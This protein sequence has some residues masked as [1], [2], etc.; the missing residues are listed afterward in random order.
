MKL[1]ASNLVRLLEQQPQGLSAKE[2]LKALGL[3]QAK[4]NQLRGVLKGLTGAKTLQR[5]NNRYRLSGKTLPQKRA[6]RK[7]QRQPHYPTGQNR[8]LV[9]WV[10]GEPQFWALG[11]ATPQTLPQV[12]FIDELI[13]GDELTFEVSE[14]GKRFNFKL[15]GRRMNVVK[16]ELTAREG[17]VYADPLPKGM[18]LG[19]Q[20]RNLPYSADLQGREALI[21]CRDLPHET[22]VVGVLPKEVSLTELYR[23]VLAEYEI[24]EPFNPKALAQAEAYGEVEKP[25]DREDLTQIP[26]VTIDGDDA[27]DFDDA[28][29]A[30]TQGEGW[31]VIVAIADVA[32]YVPPGS[33]LDKEASARSTSTYL[34]GYCVPM[35]PEHLSNGL[36]SLQA[37]KPRL[38]LA[39]EMLL[40]A[41]GECLKS[42]VFEAVIQV[43]Q[44]LT[45][46]GV[47][48]LLVQGS[49]T[50]IIP[51]L[52]PLLKLYQKIAL[53]LQAKRHQRGAID[54]SLPDVEFSFNGQNQVIGV[55]KCFQTPAQK[56][57]E[58]MMLEAN[59][60]VGRIVDEQGLSILWRNHAQPLP[61]KIKALKDLLHNEGI[62]VNRLQSGKDFN[63]ILA[64]ASQSG[65]REAIEY[66]LLRSLS[67]ALYEAKRVHHFG[68]AASH[69]LHFTSPIRRY[70]DL[71]V[72]RA[73][74]AWLKGLP[75]WKTP[76]Y[77]G[78]HTSE[79]E[80]AAQQAERAASKLQR[81]I[82]M[83]S[84]LGEVFPAKISGIHRAGVF[85]EVA[86]PYV[87]GFIP[88]AWITDDHYQV[89]VDAHKAIGRRTNRMIKPGSKLM[90]M[91][92]AFDK[93][94]RSLDFSWLC[95]VEPAEPA[96]E[97]NVS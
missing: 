14:Q 36:C 8:G 24:W 52:W 91:L 78:Q 18:P 93:K 22:Q 32:H 97:F 68:L 87:E 45:Y 57:I 66:H 29:W 20:V 33:P 1:N 30:E 42:R 44:R 5:E 51:E 77:L 80:R 34:P 88:F 39:V 89:E 53:V 27:K 54:F 50:E 86:E 11:A 21:D 83:S 60:A 69:Y 25:T 96:K 10:E 46:S 59:E 55:H 92:N 16:A 7:G 79:R 17:Q 19:I 82:L 67:L 84:R 41:Q 9:F 95:W 76:V 62:R 56:L 47:D 58:Q 4:A 38:S 63:Q 2:I 61:E 73:I 65:K 23:P 94:N 31:R 40:D 37:S 12:D 13:P 6:D 28:V 70:P 90:V 48:E 64:D 72:H 74:K 15:I 75:T 26:L 43:K 71:V 3:G 49:H 81:M 85:V 35:L